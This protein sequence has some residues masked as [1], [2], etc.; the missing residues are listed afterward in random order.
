MQGSERSFSSSACI[1]SPMS[2]EQFVRGV[3]QQPVYVQLEVKKSRHITG[4]C[5][6][7]LVAARSDTP[8]RPSRLALSPTTQLVL[9]TISSSL[10]CLA[11]SMVCLLA[12]AL[13]LG[14]GPCRVLH[15]VP[16]SEFSP[17]YGAFVLNHIQGSVLGP[18]M[19]SQ[20]HTISVSNHVRLLTW[21]RNRLVIC[22]AGGNCPTPL[23]ITSEITSLSREPLVSSSVLYSSIITH[24]GFPHLFPAPATAICHLPLSAVSDLSPAHP[25]TKTT[26]FAA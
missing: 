1:A 24:L 26:T 12:I 25:R 14:S 16:L 4:A 9:A 23:R 11:A 5:K 10:A 22:S 15:F 18:A 6:R 3:V 2:A 21:N 7:P 19:H 13:C 17:L 8:T 20:V